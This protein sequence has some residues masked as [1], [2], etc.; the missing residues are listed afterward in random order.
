MSDTSNE[1]LSTRERRHL[2]TH[3]AILNAATE[4]ISD[5]GIDGLSMRA[6]AS[7]IDY[8]PAGLYEY[9]GSKDEIVAAVCQEGNARLVRS[10]KRVDPT[11]PPHEY[12]L[13]LGHAY[14]DF[15]IRN[16]EHFML[17]FNTPQGLTS[18]APPAY[19][20]AEAIMAQMV[21][22]DSSFGLLL[23]AIQ[24]GIDDGVFKPSPGYGTLEMAHTAWA[25]VHGMA[26]LR[27][28]TL[29]DLPL[30]FAAIEAEGLERIGLAL[31]Q[32]RAA[33]E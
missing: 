18:E 17:M 25:L 1:E 21:D 24:R 26:T 16:P 30:D 6:I 31:M 10:M 27:I 14:I 15:A 12:M 8:S 2:R 29:R 7:A 19:D 5:K 32:E 3:Q 28:G 20:G 23:R 13:G 33:Q 4:I 11:L 22:D 9:F